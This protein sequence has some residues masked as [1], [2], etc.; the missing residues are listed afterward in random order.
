M[1]GRGKT[2]TRQVS[3]GP[4]LKWA[5]GKTQLL[6]E[7]ERHVPKFDRYFEPFF[8]GGAFFFRLVSEDCPITAFLSDANS[9]L[10]NAYN[11]VKRDVDQLIA[12]L[13]LHE[14]GY[15][16]DP[17]R[18]YYALRRA[19]P[20][21]NVEKAARLIALNKTCYNGLYRVNRK[22]EF[23]VPIGRYKNPVICDRAML[24]AASAALNQINV[25]LLACDYKEILKSTQEGDFVYLDPP[26]VPSSPTA[27]FVDYTAGGFGKEDQKELADTFRDL[28]RRGCKV[29]LSNSDTKLT[30]MLYADFPRS[31]VS[32]TRAISC[33]GSSR[34]GYA[35]LLVRNYT[36]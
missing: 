34:R 36:L 8:G 19:T 9:E 16:K 1:R 27:N 3:G 21:S 13:E 2:R 33:K 23:N 30:R 12:C 7:L 29:L 32:V 5:G 24:R 20:T 28:D 26:F 17:A 14:S 35:E 6:P 18:Y 31:S 15:R 25:H 22:G 4:F 11:A 10:V